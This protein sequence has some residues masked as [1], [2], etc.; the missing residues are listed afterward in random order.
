V[1]ERFLDEFAPMRGVPLAPDVKAFTARSLV[2][3]WEAAE[4]IAGAHLDSPFWAFPWP[5][6]I[7][8]A[9]VIRERPELVAGKSVIDVGAGGGVT[10]IACAL[11]GAKR[12]VGCD[13]DPWALGVTRIAARRLGLEVEISGD[14]PTEDPGVLDRFDVV[15]S[16]DLAY[17]RSH[18]PRERAALLRAANRGAAVIVAD[19]GRKYFDPDG[20]ELLATYSIEVVADVEGCAEREARVYRLK[21]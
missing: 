11:S 15:L 20:F 3:V 13:T 14:D 16:G 6:G 10:C 1:L 2:E 4:R 19:A 5:A 8:L 17:S 18:A 7:A 21:P 9:A 12:V